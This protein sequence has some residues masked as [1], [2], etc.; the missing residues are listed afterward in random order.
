VDEGIGGLRVW[1]E[2][3]MKTPTLTAIRKSLKPRHK[4]AL[5]RAKVALRRLYSKMRYGRGF[6]G[7]DEILDAAERIIFRSKL[8]GL[9]RGTLREI[10]SLRR[11]YEGYKMH[12]E[13]ALSPVSGALSRIDRV[14]GI[15]KRFSRK[16]FRRHKPSIPW[17]I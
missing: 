16:G 13:T 1:S 7:W 3:A 6:L 14:L 5:K 12:A 15:G 8:P 9:F 10:E 11:R 2:A 4:A 17:T